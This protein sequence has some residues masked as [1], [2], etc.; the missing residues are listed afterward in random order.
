MKMVIYVKVW[1]VKQFGVIVL[2]PIFYIVYHKAKW[3]LDGKDN[4][5]YIWKLRWKPCYQ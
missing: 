5:M 3:W 4:A 1:F 2:Y